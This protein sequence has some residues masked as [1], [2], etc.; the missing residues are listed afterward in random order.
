M[1]SIIYTQAT[2]ATL[3]SGSAPYG[4][5][6]NGAVAISK[7]RIVWCGE[8]SNIPAHLKDWDHCDLE[9]ALVTPSL[10]DCHTHI[11]HGGNR[12]SEFEMRLGGAAYEEISNA[13]GGIVSTVKDTRAAS[14]EEL[15]R[16][17]LK[18]VDALISEGVSCLEVKSGYGLD[19]ETELKMLRVARSI[20]KARP[21]RVRTS[22][23]G[24]HAIPPKY[25]DRADDYIDDICIPALETAHK[26]RLVDAVDGFCETIGFTPAQIERVFKKAGELDLP[27]KLHA[28]QLSNQGGAALAAKPAD[29]SAGRADSRA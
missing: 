29:L 5:L 2:L 11:V 4:L 25:K 27:V 23:L 6:D 17:A 28:E 24:A 22:F 8:T 15:L 19:I 16:S 18:R 1:Q 26:E 21:I 9:G 20:E 7:G 10:I 13:G 14:E 3:Q 12:A